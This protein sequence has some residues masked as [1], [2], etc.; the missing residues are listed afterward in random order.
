LV[1]IDE[2]ELLKNIEKL[3][4]KKIPKIIVEGFKPDPTIEAEPI[5]N[6]RGRARP[7][8]S[9]PRQTNDRRRNSR[10]R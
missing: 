7:K 4:K 10:S 3:I 2:H 1:C 9:T 8:S 5:Q 6:Q